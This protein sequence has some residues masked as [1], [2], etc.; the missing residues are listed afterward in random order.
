MASIVTASPAFFKKTAL[1]DAKTSAAA[2]NGAIINVWSVFP[3]CALQLSEE[4]L[5]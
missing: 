3:Y 4:V 5:S 1:L 2:K